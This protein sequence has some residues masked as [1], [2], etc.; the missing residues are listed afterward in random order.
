MGYEIEQVS[1]LG[2]VPGKKEPKWPQVVATVRKMRPDSDDSIFVPQPVDSSL[3]VR[4]MGIQIQ[5]EVRTAGMCV[6]TRHLKRNGTEFGVRI[7]RL[8]D[9]AGAGG[10]ARVAAQQRDGV[11]RT[12]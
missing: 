8:K 12:W 1:R 2:L 7:W 5:H 9:S 4:G 11:E 6:T 10:H 3:T